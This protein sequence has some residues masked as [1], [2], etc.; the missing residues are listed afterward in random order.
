[1]P[2]GV[3]LSREQISSVTSSPTLQ[4]PASQR[5][6]WKT[7]SNSWFSV[8]GRWKKP[9]KNYLF[10][11]LTSRYILTRLKITNWTSLNLQVCHVI[12][13]L[14]DVS[15]HF[16]IC[17]QRDLVSEFHSSLSNTKN[18]PLMLLVDGV[19]L[20]QDGR[21]LLS[22]DWIPQQLP[23]V[24]LHDRKHTLISPSLFSAYRLRKIKIK[25]QIGVFS[26]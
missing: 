19:D 12:S 24:S 8:W 18:K 4:L 17:D 5:A 20:I 15:F 21:G 16:I 13:I 11:I 22:S 3:D 10:L 9:R 6:L 25:L 7:C 1:M 23:Q 2:S 14:I 26:N